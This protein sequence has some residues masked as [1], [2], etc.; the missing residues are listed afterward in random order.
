[1]II[2]DLDN[3]MIR[4]SVLL[5][6]ILLSFVAATAYSQEQ[7][8]THFAISEG[9]TLTLMVPK[10]LGNYTNFSSADGKSSLIFG[11]SPSPPFLINIYTVIPAGVSDSN[12][13]RNALRR[14]VE[15][16][17]TKYA[18]SAV[19]PDVQIREFDGPYVSGYS[20]SLTDR[21][22]KPD[23]YK[24]LTEVML[25]SGRLVMTGYVFTNDGASDVVDDAIEMLKNARY[26][27]E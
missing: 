2:L 19:E 18:V 12:F 24:Y 9:G 22:P 14:H 15:D 1:V 3:N 8:E 11:P 27:D 16:D 20:F 4:R 7:L 25:R 26:E 5:S 6:T 10:P 23:E 21:A 13:M 17:A